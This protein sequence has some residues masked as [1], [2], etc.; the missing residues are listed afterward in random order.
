MAKGIEYIAHL[1]A[2]SE[3]ENSNLR[4]ANEALSKRRRAKKIQVRK[5]GS[6][7]VGDAQD[8]I[9]QREVDEQ[10]SHKKRRNSSKRKPR[11]EGIRRCGIC[12]ESGHNA[13]TYANDIDIS[14]EDSEED[15]E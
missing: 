4:R 2:L 6:L 5:G 9:S 12:G 11:I 15:S 13:R 7:T 3:K 1:L 10:L 8:L 14:K